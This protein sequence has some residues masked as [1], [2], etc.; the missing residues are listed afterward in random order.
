M[1]RLLAAAFAVLAALSASAAGAPKPKAELSRTAGK[2]L[3]AQANIS[4]SADGPVFREGRITILDKADHVEEF[5]AT[6]RTKVTLDGKP[7]KFQKAAAPGALVLKALYDPNT[8]ELSSLDLKSGPR[9]DGDDPKAVEAVR[10]EVANTDVLKGIL[11][12][13][14]GRQAISEFT[15]PETAKIRR[16]A[17][18]KPGEAVPFEA[19]QVGDAV[20]VFSPD[21]KTAVEIHARAAAR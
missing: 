8:K 4:P 1:N 18:G 9:P 21:G 16:E 6:K 15:V 2:V 5:K 3:K 19:L 10:G 20:E 12:V 14:T 13:R 11:T 17:E 7:A